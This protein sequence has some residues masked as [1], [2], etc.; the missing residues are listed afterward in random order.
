[1]I[2][3]V[4]NNRELT[5]HFQIS[6][7]EAKM[8]SIY[9]VKSNLNSFYSFSEKNRLHFLIFMHTIQHETLYENNFNS[10]DTFDSA[11]RP[12]SSEICRG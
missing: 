4:V 12:L 9:W 5:S 7:S 11:V 10:N 1:M 2:H 3:P 6:F 8:G